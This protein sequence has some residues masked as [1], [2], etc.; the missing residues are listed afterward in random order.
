MPKKSIESLA[1]EVWSWLETTSECKNLRVVK[2]AIAL[3]S[4]VLNTR[5]AEK[6]PGNLCFEHLSFV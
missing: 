4:H 1:G 2:G 5:D 6:I 3:A